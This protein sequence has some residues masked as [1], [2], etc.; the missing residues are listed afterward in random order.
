M[1]ILKALLH[2]KT[3]RDYRPPNGRICDPVRYS[4][5]KKLIN[6]PESD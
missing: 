4:C 1:T 2:Q 3:T 5:Q 6:E